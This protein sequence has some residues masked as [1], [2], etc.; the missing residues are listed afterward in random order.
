[1][2][3]VRAPTVLRQG[4][5]SEPEPHEIW[6]RGTDS[7]GALA[8][9]IHDALEDHP[10]VDVACMGAAPT[11]SGAKAVAELRKLYAETHHP[12]VEIFCQ[13]FFST[14]IDAHGEERNRIVFRVFSI[15]SPAA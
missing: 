8:K 3:L 5:V 10:Y 14:F 6:V 9:N 13:P 2:R 12:G 1:M 15:Y 4:S 7:I 11:N